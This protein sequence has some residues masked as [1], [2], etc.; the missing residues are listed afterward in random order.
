MPH[1]I[2]DG[3]TLHYEQA[4]SRA[5][6][7]VFVHGWCCD[8]T[9]FAP[10]FRHFATSSSVTTYDLRGCGQSAPA[11]DYAVAS[12]ADELAWLCAE[13]AIVRPV[14][15]GHSLGGA[16]ALEAAAR[17]PSMPRAVVAVDP[18]P[19][20]PLPEFREALSALIAQLR[21]SAED[22]PRHAYVAKLFRPGDDLA[23]ARRI[24]DTMCS[25]P[26]D[27]AAAVLEGY[28][29]WDGVAALARCQV[30]IL[31]VTPGAGGSNAPA[32][33]LALDPDIQIGVTVGAGH[34]LQFDA[35]DQLTPMIERFVRDVL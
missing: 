14:L 23:R 26:R 27:L 18:A 10:Q 20:D 34:F 28:L 33:L 21:D 5:P 19:F 2:R 7:F 16:I 22:D 4:G 29:A 9:F 3:L 15:V 11:E 1:A 17:H 8:H 25:V 12:F 6:A 35:A 30:P 24:E 31:V 32:R 13:L